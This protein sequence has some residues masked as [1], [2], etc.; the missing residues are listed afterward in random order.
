MR[1]VEVVVKDGTVLYPEGDAVTITPMGE[2]VVLDDQGREVA[3]F[4]PGNWL[5][6]QVLHHLGG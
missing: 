2:L 3:R 1:G 5:G 4:D 6:S